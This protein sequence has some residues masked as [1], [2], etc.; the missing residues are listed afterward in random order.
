MFSYESFCTPGAG[1]HIS[2]S[3]IGVIG[4]D[5]QLAVLWVH[6]G[7]CA[8]GQ[9]AKV[10]LT[11]GQL[12]VA[13]APMPFAAQ[14]G[15]LA[16]GVALRGSAP[17]ALAAQL[18]PAS[19]VL[20]VAECPDAVGLLPQLAVGKRLPPAERSILAYTL[21]CR[22]AAVLSDVR[23]PL[24]T[25]HSPLVAAALGKINAQY[26]EVYGVEELAAELEVSKSHLI[27]LFTAAVGIAPGKYLTAVRIE[28]AK[29]LMNSGF[30]LELVAGMC[31]FSGANYL[32]RVFKKTTGISPGEWRARYAAAGQS[33]LEEQPRDEMYL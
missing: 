2:G 3:E 26:A 30:S 16:V 18:R 21:V 5:G 10:E 19:R 12:L 25:V 31:G 7:G 32:C 9:D 24:Q 22:L 13:C 27:R 15:C 17:E 11:T 6:Q 8:A 23:E 28:A 1:R 33:T 4:D 20:P 29:S 14:A